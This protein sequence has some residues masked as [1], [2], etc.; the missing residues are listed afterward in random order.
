MSTLYFNLILGAT[1]LLICI[2]AYFSR[3]LPWH[4]L[5]SV[6]FLGAAGGLL[7]LNLDENQFYLMRLACYAIFLH[8]TFLV[9]GLGLILYNTFPISAKF[10]LVIAALLIIATIDAFVIEPIWTETTTYT[11]QSDK[12]KQP[13]LIA[14][15][16]DL[17]TDQ[18]GAY[19]KEVLQQV[20]DAKPDLILLP[21]DYIQIANG[22]ERQ[23]VSK[24][25]R[26][27][28]KEINFTAPL[29][30][31]AVRGNVEANNWTSIFQGL[32]I[33]CIT[34]QQS[35]R[36]QELTITGLGL[37]ESFD[38]RKRINRP[39]KNQFHLV[40]GHGPDFALGKVDADLLV[41]GHTHGG[42][43]RLP[44]F[45]PPITLSR[46]PRDWAAGHTLLDKD[47]HLVVSRGIGTEGGPAPRLRFLCRPEL[48]FIELESKK[49]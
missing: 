42:Q 30:V 14:V 32:P 28:L 39:Q 8:G 35:I 11:I 3:K 24:H 37:W 34:A 27:Y 10:F 25:L 4:I 1:V 29:G 21:G 26:D 17:Q 7:Y 38:T 15:I 31:Y 18:I 9:M 13:L 45:G 22:K 43:V 46:V 6:I 12:I 47:K 41:A 16:A 2:V 49:E 5:G 19:E 44:F 40:F 33:R 48:V 20:M 36:L 23:K